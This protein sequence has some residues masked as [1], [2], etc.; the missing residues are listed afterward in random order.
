MTHIDYQDLATF[1]KYDHRLARHIAQSRGPTREQGIESRLAL[2]RAALTQWDQ[3][4]IYSTH[5]ASLC[6]TYRAT[7]HY[8]EAI[9]NLDQHNH[10]CLAAIYLQARLYAAA[11]RMPDALALLEPLPAAGHGIP[12]RA[13]AEWLTLQ[14][15]QPSPV[16]LPAIEPGHPMAAITTLHRAALNQDTSLGRWA[17]LKVLSI[18]DLTHPY[19]PTHAPWAIDALEHAPVDWLPD[20]IKAWGTNI[21]WLV[22]PSN[23]H[24][25]AGLLE[26][27]HITITQPASARSTSA[28]RESRLLDLIEH[29]NLVLATRHYI[30]ML[31]YTRNRHEAVPTQWTAHIDSVWPA[32][33]CED[34]RECAISLAERELLTSERAIGASLWYQ[35][36]WHRLL[37]GQPL[38]AL[39]VARTVHALQSCASAELEIK[40]A[41]AC[42]AGGDYHRAMDLSFRL[43]RNRALAREAGQILAAASAQSGFELPRIR[44]ARA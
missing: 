25:L 4:A 23:R 37:N 15:G 30:R 11:G 26:R 36:V 3:G 21:W 27:L 22:S 18:S 14:T 10:D 13:Y 19:L 29:N 12:V 32:N 1:R 8:L 41:Q 6:L 42:L 38:Y 17:L 40:V 5:F 44:Q 9:D 43:I 34:Q 7:S 2:T 35:Y 31:D 24:K 33:L 20:A 16:S 39:R 28:R